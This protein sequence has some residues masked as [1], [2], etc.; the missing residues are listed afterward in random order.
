V[1]VV[2]LAMA[3]FGFSPL[4]TGLQGLYFDAAYARDDYRAIAARI[5]V[6][7]GPSAAVILDAPN[8][9][10]VFTYYYPD[11]PNVTPCRMPHR[12]RQ[13]PGCWRT[14]TGCTPYSGARASRTLR[15]SSR[16]RS[17]L[18]LSRSMPPGMA[19]SSW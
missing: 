8:Q 9:K 11:G 19:R 18:A 1:R 17:R 2:V 14:I 16:P 5:T 3:L 15:V 7:A 4:V 13:S 10:E 12:I 6:E